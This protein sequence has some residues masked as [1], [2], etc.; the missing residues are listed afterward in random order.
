[1]RIYC[2]SGLGADERVFKYLKL[3]KEFDLIPISWIIP[4]HNESIENYAKRISENI[5][6]D[7]PYGILGVSFGGLVAQEVSMV[8]N[9]KFIFI[10]SS[11]N[12]KSQVPLMLKFIPKWLINLLPSF[13]FNDK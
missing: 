13:L 10:I 8:L 9:P 12:D 7:K 6:T 5:N 3:D 11:I 2:F 4:N 1:M